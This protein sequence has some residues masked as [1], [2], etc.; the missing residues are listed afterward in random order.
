MSAPQ[1]KTYTEQAKQAVAAAGQKA[2][3]AWE[4]TRETV[5]QV[6]MQKRPSTTRLRPSKAL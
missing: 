2:G 4:A 3:E 5:A 6:R 1:D